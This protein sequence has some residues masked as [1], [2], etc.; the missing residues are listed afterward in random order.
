MD[1]ERGVYTLDEALNLAGFGK[2]QSLVLLY[3]GLGLIA[4]AM[5]IMLLSFIGTAIKSEWGLLQVK[6]AF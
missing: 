3:A 1:D 5:E 2:Y 6:K 4:E